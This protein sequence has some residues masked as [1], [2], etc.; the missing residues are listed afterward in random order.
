MEGKRQ[1]IVA[2]TFDLYRQYGIKSVSM[3]DVSRELGM[4]KKTLYQYVKDKNELVDLVLLYLKQFLKDSFSVFHDESLNAIEQHFEFRKRME[5]KT[6]RYQPTFLF[7][8]KKYYPAHL[9][10]VKNVKIDTIYNANI[11]NLKKGKQEGYY[12]EDIDESIIAR[13]NVSY[14]VYTFDPGNGLF[15]DAEVTDHKTFAEVY[16]YHF[17][18]ICTEEGMKELQRLF[19][20]NNITND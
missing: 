5:P 17:R 9:Q 19:C 2:R 15:T 10:E 14:H 18:G 13:I 8:L 11:S 12:R 20:D 3:D 1:E 7:D 6:G 16:K 4:S